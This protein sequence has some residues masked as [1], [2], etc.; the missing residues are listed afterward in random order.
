MHA[1]YNIETLRLILILQIF[2]NTYT[3]RVQRA[4]MF[5]KARV[6]LPG[7]DIYTLRTIVTI[8]FP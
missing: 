4:T 1:A 7:D 6:A 5:G 2:T 8:A 3:V